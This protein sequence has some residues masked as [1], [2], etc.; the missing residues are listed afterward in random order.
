MKISISKLFGTLFL[1]ISLG[2]FSQNNEKQE[3]FQ[4]HIE[5]LEYMS[6]KTNTNYICILLSVTDVIIL[7]R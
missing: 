5:T 3:R 4:Q 7:Q 1:L 6:R 2:V